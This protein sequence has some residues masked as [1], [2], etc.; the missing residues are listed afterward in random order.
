VVEIGYNGDKF[1]QFL[2]VIENHGT[3]ARSQRRLEKDDG[4][5]SG[6]SSGITININDQ[7]SV[8]LF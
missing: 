4:I 7:R 1:L 2:N 3:L 5:R 6:I 8:A